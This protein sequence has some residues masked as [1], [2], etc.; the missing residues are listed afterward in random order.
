MRP[1]TRRGHCARKFTLIELLV[2]VAIISILAAMLLPAL[3][4]AREKARRATC[5]AGQKQ[6]LGA[7]GMY[8]GDYDDFIYYTFANNYNI[9]PSQSYLEGYAGTGL[10]G[11]PKLAGLSPASAGYYCDANGGFPTARVLFKNKYVADYRSIICSSTH[12]KD[13]IPG[14]AGQLYKGWFYINGRTT[15][16]GDLI[17]GESPLYT[18]F[19]TYIGPGGYATNGGNCWSNPLGVYKSF[20]V[21]CIHDGYGYKNDV[22]GAQIEGTWQIIDCPTNIQTYPGP[23]CRT[24]SPHEFKNIGAANQNPLV[25]HFRNYGYNDGH[26]EGNYG[27]FGYAGS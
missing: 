20:T 26:V 6:F 23:D 14:I 27:R 11:N 8:H 15:T 7:L 25:P 1:S 18:P 16:Y 13:E 9:G 17:N 22:P 2:V 5:V 10:P 12:G 24:Y 3:S 21:D 19:F 4:Q